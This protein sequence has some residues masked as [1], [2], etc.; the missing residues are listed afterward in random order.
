MLPFTRR[1]EGKCLRG[2]NTLNKVN[3]LHHCIYFTRK[4]EIYFEEILKALALRRNC[5]PTGSASLLYCQ[6]GSYF[7]GNFLED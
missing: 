5:T 7:F 2:I 3:S 1:Q 6:I 4:I